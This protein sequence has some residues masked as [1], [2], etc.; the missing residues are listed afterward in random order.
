[1]HEMLKAALALLK[2]FDQQDNKWTA[3]FP[4]GVFGTLRMGCGNDYLM[5]SPLE[6]ERDPRQSNGR[7]WGGAREDNRGRYSSHHKAFMP[8]FVAHGLSISFAYSKAAV[9]EVFTYKPDEWNQMIGSVDN[10]EGFHPGGRRWQGGYWRT[11]AYLHILP[12]DYQHKQFKGMGMG[13]RVLPIPMEEWSKYP[14]VPCW[15]YSSIRENKACEERLGKEHSP[16]IWYG[17]DQKDDDE[18]DFLL[19]PLDGD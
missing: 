1:M 18:E 19:S 11:L 3:P 16:I 4:M 5:G 6:G 13:D 7:W 10:L 12:D 9:F 14:H 17:D 2:E 15:V 8:H